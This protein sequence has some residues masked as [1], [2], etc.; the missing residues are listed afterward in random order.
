MRYLLFLLL[1]IYSL[2]A[3]ERPFLIT[4]DK[5]FDSVLYAVTQ[6][7]DTNSVTAVGYTN[8]FKQKKR[9]KS[10]TNAFDYLADASENLYG[11]K[12]VLVKV[13]SRNAKVR[14]EKFARIKEFNEAVAILKTPQN[15]YF[16]GGYTFDGSLLVAR[17]DADA[18]TL[19]VRKFGTKNYDRMNNL[20]ALSDG[21]VLAIGSSTTSRDP[22][23]PMFRTGLGLNDIFI[24]RFD[25]NG[26]MLWS[27]KYGT[28]YDDRGIDAAEAYDGSLLVIASTRYDKHHDVT[29]MRLG[30]NGDKIWLKHY[31]TDSLLS[32]RR[33]IAL[34]DNNFLAVLSQQDS[35]GKR[36]VRLL[37]FDLQKNVLRDNTLSTYYESELNDIREFSNGT[38]IAVGKTKDRYNTDALVMVLDENLE[39]LCQEHFGTPNYD[40]FNGVTIL[41]DGSSMAVG[42][43]TPKSSQVKHMY[44]AKIL[45][46]CTLARYS[47]SAEAKR[48]KTPT[49]TAAPAKLYEELKKLFKDEI[50]AKEL[51]VTPELEI[52]LL[53]EKLLFDAG[54]YRLNDSQKKLLRKI[55]KRLVS[56]VKK[57]KKQ[58]AA[59]EITGHTSS[60]WESTNSFKERYNNNMN[61]SLKRSYSVSTFLFN[62]QD[63][64]TQKMLASLLKDSGYS[65]AKNIK[66]GN[67]EDKRHSRRVVLRIVPKM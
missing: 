14:F 28:E 35:V 4:I 21:G 65:F 5:P 8:N 34:H 13:S 62:M 12:S 54:E 67:E 48:N 58:I 47:S 39:M 24:T 29:L 42:L 45:P 22:Y 59:I 17:L 32:P 33:L 60:E 2:N 66:R 56:F 51:Q 36:Q 61:L 26:N 63:S 40:I 43:T 50:A 20:I 38:F 18:N 6:D 11:K 53:G 57:H 25:A 10:Y 49:R 41:R 9:A 55:S 19:F 15:G 44:M 64:S 27:R 30:E 31:K 52:V 16:I 37:K 46:D 23:D 7:Y 1:A 3:D